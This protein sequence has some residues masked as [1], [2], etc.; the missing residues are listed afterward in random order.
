MVKGFWDFW[1]HMPH[2]SIRKFKNWK[3]FCN[4]H[5]EG[6]GEVH[7]HTDLSNLHRIGR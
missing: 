5:N 2:T 3:M 1:N 4:P 7:R 6:K